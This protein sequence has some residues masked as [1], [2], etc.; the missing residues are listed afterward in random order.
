[1]PNNNFISESGTIPTALQAAAN[2]FVAEFTLRTARVAAGKA[3]STHPIEALVAEGFALMQEVS[4]TKV[5]AARARLQRPLA[6]Y[7]TNPLFARYASANLDT[8]DG[9]NAS[10][11]SR[12]AFHHT[13]LANLRT[14]Y[15][16]IASPLALAGAP[17]NILAPQAE[18]QRLRLL[19]N[20]VRCIDE[21]GTEPFGELGSDET[22]LTFTAVDE[23]GQSQNN[24][25]FKVRQFN[26]NTTKVYSP[27]TILANFNIHEGGN[28]FPKVYTGVINL[29]E[30]DNGK[31]ADWAKKIIDVVKSKVASALAT[32][33]GVAIGSALGPLGAAIGAAVGWAVNQIVALLVAW[34]EDDN[35]GT[36]ALQATINSYTG[37]LQNNLASMTGS[38]DLTGS[39]SRYRVFYTWSLV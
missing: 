25:Q 16:H 14:S 37:K 39:N 22:Y 12:D 8:P 30:H 7:R 9:L 1:M 20:E 13:A 18:F 28:T 10:I 34:W 38:F 26:D 6:T 2:D 33:I 32:A 19:L 27:P 5:A 3:A 15:V 36:K 4:P 21:T 35:I 29:M 11:T 17:P 31:V 23:N 24:T